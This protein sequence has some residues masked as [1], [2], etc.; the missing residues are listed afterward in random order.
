MERQ[1]GKDARRAAGFAD[2]APKIPATAFREFQKRCRSILWRADGGRAEKPTYDKW[3]ARI[4]ELMDLDSELKQEEAT[5]RASKEFPILLRLFKEY[6]LT[7]FDP[8]PDLFPVKAATDEDD[9][10]VVPCADLEQTWLD[11]LR[12]ANQAAGRRLRTGKD[13]S[14]CP[15]DRAWWL[16]RMAL[17]ES[18]EFFNRLQQA[19]REATQ[20]NAAKVAGM[21]AEQV[22]MDQIDQMLADAAGEA[23]P[24]QDAPE[25]D[26]TEL[27]DTDGRDDHA[28]ALS[29]GAEGLREEPAIPTDDP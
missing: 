10:D 7:E 8:N 2:V 20:A 16:Y 12:W 24:E 28:E 27:G 6:D 18:K 1:A 25:Q 19:E 15:N 9:E 3:Q 21:G 13:P 22:A 17:E 29:A 5:V 26:E 14:S 11:D 4:K 23:A